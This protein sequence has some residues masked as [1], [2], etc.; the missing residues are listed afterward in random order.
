M[1]DALFTGMH[2]DRRKCRKDNLKKWFNPKD[3]HAFVKNTMFS[4][5]NDSGCFGF[6]VHHLP[7]AY[8]KSTLNEVWKAD[9]EWLDLAS[10]HRF[11]DAG[12]VSQCVFKFWQLCSGDFYPYNKRKF[13]RVFRSELEMDALCDAIRTSKYKTICIND[14]DEIDFEMARKQ[15]NEAFESV[16]SEKSAFE[17]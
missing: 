13:G 7:Q 6:N 10:S 14:A 15:V 11:R 4:L 2:F 9:P 12:D 16:F 8:K 1:N 3:P 5:L 17:L